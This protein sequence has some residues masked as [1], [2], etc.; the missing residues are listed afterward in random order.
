MKATV[1]ERDARS[2]HQVLTVLETSSSPAPAWAATHA[3]TCTAMPPNSSTTSH[4]PV[5]IER[6]GR[7]AP[8]CPPEQKRRA[9][10]L[11]RDARL[12]SP[13]AW[14]AGRN[15]ARRDA[16]P[17]RRPRI[18]RSSTDSPRARRADD[19]KRSGLLVGPR[20]LGSSGGSPDRATRFTGAPCSRLTAALRACRRQAHSRALDDGRVLSPSDG[21]HHHNHSTKRCDDQLKPQQLWRVH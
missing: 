13:I 5:G 7:A 10:A 19:D 1:A 11:T 14:C 2:G 6:F 17:G 21:E 4:S 16:S 8:C 15:G 18:P 20:M 3:P 12:R 9:C